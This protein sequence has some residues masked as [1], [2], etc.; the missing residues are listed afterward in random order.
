MLERED[1]AVEPGLDALVVDEVH[2]LAPR[3]AERHH[4]CPGL[5][6][7][8]GAAVVDL[9]DVAEVDLCHFARPGLYRD[10]DVVGGDA[11]LALEPSDEA[12][13]G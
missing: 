11:D 4:E 8:A 5:A 9:A 10:H 12:L 6:A 1:V 13:H 7:D 3:E 2:E